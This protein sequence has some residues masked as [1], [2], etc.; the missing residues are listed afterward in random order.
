MTTQSERSSRRQRKPAVTW[1]DLERGLAATLPALGL[2]HLVIS[3]KVGNRFVQFA[4]D[5]EEGLRAEVVSN[6][7]LEPAD[8]H[9]DACQ[10]ELLALGWKGPTH[11]ADA[12]EGERVAHGSPNYFCDWEPPVV[13]WDEVARLAVNTLRAVGV[14]E[15]AAL[16]YTAWDDEDRPLSLPALRLARREEKPAR[17]A[18]RAPTQKRSAKPGPVPPA[19]KQ[20]RDNLLAAARI[21]QANNALQLDENG[22]IPVRFGRAFG[23][24][25]V[26]ANPVVVRVYCQLGHNVAVTER[27]LRRLHEVN[28]KWSLVR[29][30]LVE[31]SVFAAVDFTA[32]P[33]SVEHFTTACSVLRAV[34]RDHR[35]EL[36]SVSAQS[37]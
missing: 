11:A 36:Q 5:P 2:A 9:S 28:A 27:L 26:F 6:E 22:E 4:S 18:R 37:S 34:E 24:I 7:Y 21:F 33:F 1:A 17:A 23:R 35:D 30:V 8:R 20:L 15:P 13:P 31:R 12:Q 16:E 29:L 3:T 10:A 32:E 25:Q 19:V 14:A